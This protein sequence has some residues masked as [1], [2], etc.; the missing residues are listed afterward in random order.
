[1][2][3]LCAVSVPGTADKWAIPHADADDYFRRST[4][5]PYREQQDGPA[6]GVSGH[7]AAILVQSHPVTG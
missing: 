5:L 3:V 2:S 7:R 6:G 1:M 4:S